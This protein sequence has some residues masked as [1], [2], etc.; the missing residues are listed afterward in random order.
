MKDNSLHPLG[1]KSINL[2]DLH[3]W[4][5]WPNPSDDVCFLPESYM[6]AVN[7]FHDDFYGYAKWEST[8][9]I[10]YLIVFF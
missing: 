2:K 10:Y 3:A 6:K 9:P 8:L 1:F 4:V 7:N 5:E